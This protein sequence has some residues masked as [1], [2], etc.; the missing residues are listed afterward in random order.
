MYSDES[1]ANARLH[2]ASVINAMVTTESHGW[3]VKSPRREDLTSQV[4][5]PCSRAH[6]YTLMAMFVSAMGIE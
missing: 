1:A 2:Q 6:E 5:P 3:T 4:H